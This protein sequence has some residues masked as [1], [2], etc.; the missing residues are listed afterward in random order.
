VVD[1]HPALYRATLTLSDQKGTGSGL[2]HLQ[3]DPHDRRQTGGQLGLTPAAGIYRGAFI[4]PAE[5][6][7]PAP[8]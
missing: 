3:R 7:D 1:G 2:R 6:S 8:P 5:R 4:P